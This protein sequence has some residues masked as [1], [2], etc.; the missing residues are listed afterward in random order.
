MTSLAQGKS[1]YV[2]YQIYQLLSAPQGGNTTEKYSYD[3]V[4]NQFSSLGAPSCSYNLS[5]R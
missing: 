2:Y 1:N 5:E 4:G 3:P